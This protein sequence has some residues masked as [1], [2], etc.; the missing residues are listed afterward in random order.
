M[1]IRKSIHV[2]VLLALLFSISPAQAQTSAPPVDMFQL[3]WEQGRSWVAFDGFDNG[4]RRSSTSP[5]NYLMGGAVDFAP[6]TNMRVGDDTSNDW[7]VAAAAGTVVAVSYCHVVINHNSGWLTEYWHLGNIQVTLGQRV[8]R[9]QRLAVIHNNAGQQICAGNQFPGPHLHFVARPQMR[10]FVFSGWVINFNVSTNV[11]TYTKNGTTVGKLQPILNI[12]NLQVVSRGLLEWDTLYTGS[13]DTYR[14]ERWSLQ[15]TETT[16]F[17]LRIPTTTNGLVPVIVLLDGS[18]VELARGG[19]ALTSVQPAGS[20]IVQIQSGVGT[21]FYDLIATREGGPTPTETPTATET[22]STGTPIPTDPSGTPLVTETPVPT[23]P[24]GTPLV[25]ETPIPTDPSGTP[26]V[27]NTPTPATGSE[28]PF[29]TNTP[30]PTDPSGTPFVTDTPIPTDPS[31]TPFVT[32]TPTPTAFPTDPSETP[33]VTN[34]P[35]STSTS[36]TPFGTATNTFIPTSTP[37]VTETS[38]ATVTPI[39]TG[40]PMPTVTPVATITSLPTGPYVLTDALLSTIPIGGTSL[41]NVSLVNIP[42]EGYTSAEFTCSY[43]PTLLSVSDIAVANLFGPDPVA[44]INGPLNGT[45]ILAMAG[46]N[47]NRATADGVAFSFIVTGLQVGQTPVECTARVSR[48][49]GVLESIQSVPDGVTVLAFL[50]SPT[51]VLAT[52]VNG[53][54]LAGKPVTISLYDAGSALVAVQ[55]ANPDGTFSIVADAGTYTIIASAEGF[56]N[57]QGSVTLVNGVVTTMPTVSLPAGDIDGNGVINYFDALTIGMNYGSSTPSAADLNN[58]GVID[59]L[60]LELLAFYY[61][62]SG[63][64]AWQ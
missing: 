6:R 13:V 52:S 62:A 22:P 31:G 37:I 1:R 30:I 4:S 51:P 46:S 14:R 33:L 18:G 59:I 27:T 64:L 55:I 54:V 29:V 40:T 48:G 12:P 45:F 61:N 16:A 17:E 39:A 58:D 2:F 63:A 47:N 42:A 15:L 28:T 7:V 49:L 57:A 20:Y 60:D 38:G 34:T 3:P 41:V 36:D 24:S 50:P 9:N 32:N 25:T 5:H 21:G 43:D 8:S 10:D 23:D 44:A 26:L 35:I 11:T 19:G 53:T 56:L